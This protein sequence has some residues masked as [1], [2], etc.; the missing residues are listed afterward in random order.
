M[1]FHE[2]SF[3]RPASNTS[4]TP[5]LPIP[6]LV[7]ETSKAQGL[8]VV[9]FE[10]LNLVVKFGGPPNVKLEE[11]QVMWA[12]GKLFP[13][14][15]VPVP[16]LFGWRDKTSIWGQLNQMVASIRRI[17]QPSFQPL[18]GSINY[19][20]VQD[21]YFRGGEEARP[22]HA[23]SAFNDW[24]QFTAL[25]WLPVS[26]RPADPYRPLLPDTCK[27]HFTHAD[28]HLY[29]IIISDTP[30]CRSIVGIVD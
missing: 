4:P 28:L 2:S 7:R 30:G 20:Q 24:V 10:N 21:I 6:E 27:V 3:F 5:Q 19:G 18:I 29:N 1:D 14:K 23:V 17:Q 22:F 15:D 9:M 12:I 11:A 26:E 13:T 8:S 25:P 16:E